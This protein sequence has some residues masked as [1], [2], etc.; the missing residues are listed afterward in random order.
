MKGI[1][2][3]YIV[4][5]RQEST[6]KSA[7]WIAK[8]V[9]YMIKERV[10]DKAKFSEKMKGEGFSKSNK[11]SNSR[12]LAPTTQSMGL[13]MKPCGVRSVRKKHFLRCDE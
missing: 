8:S 7:I 5:V 12:S 10:I 11:K 4:Q 2:W 1:P 6:L 3:E 13:K 9:E